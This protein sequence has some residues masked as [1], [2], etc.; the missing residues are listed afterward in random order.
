MKGD[1]GLHEQSNGAEDGRPAVAICRVSPDRV[2]F[3]EQGN[4]DGWI[5][6]DLTVRVGR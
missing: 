5:A 3:T 1:G 2:L 4:T 6:T